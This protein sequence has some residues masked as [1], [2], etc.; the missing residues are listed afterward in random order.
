MVFVCVVLFGF[1]FIDP[2][3]AT[4]D[5]D[6]D[7]RA[8]A[9]GL[10]AK[11]LRKRLP[12]K[13]EKEDLNNRTVT[14]ILLLWTQQLFATMLFVMGRRSARVFSTLCFKSKKKRSAP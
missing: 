13:R 7:A 14:C 2:S 3:N 8:Y 12:R 9:R 11:C 6:R 10:G 5:E 1:F 4:S